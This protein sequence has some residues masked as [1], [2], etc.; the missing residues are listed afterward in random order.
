ML[1]QVSADLTS[2]L[3]TS[4]ENLIGTSLRA[5]VFPHTESGE[6]LINRIMIASCIEH[7]L[8]AGHCAKYFN[9]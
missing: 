3:P 2:S 6:G 4:W 9:K 1:A 5:L 8:H 7:S